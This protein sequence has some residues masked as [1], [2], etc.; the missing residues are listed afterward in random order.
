M[1]KKC[2]VALLLI[3]SGFATT[4]KAGSD[5]EYMKRRFPNRAIYMPYVL[6]TSDTYS[7]GSFFEGYPRRS[8]QTDQNLAWYQARLG[9]TLHLDSLDQLVYGYSAEGLTDAL[10]AKN[11]PAHLRALKSDK[12]LLTYLLIAKEVEALRASKDVWGYEP[13]SE[14]T[15]RRERERLLKTVMSYKQG[16]LLDRYTLLACRLLT[17]Q[18]RYAEVIGLWTER[19]SLFANNVIKEM[20]EGYVARAWHNTGKIKEAKE[21]YQRI[22][23]LES[24]LYIYRIEHKQPVLYQIDQLRIGLQWVTEHP[25]YVRILTRLLNYTEAY[26]LT[27]YK[28][29]QEV[30]KK[31]PNSAFWNYTMAFIYERHK[32]EAPF[33][34][35]EAYAYLKQAQ[36]A[37]K[38]V[39]PQLG[40]EISEDLQKAVTLL[41]FHSGIIYDEA[42]QREVIDWF[43][44]EMLRVL[45]KSKREGFDLYE[46]HRTGLLA[47]LEAEL[48]SCFNTS[49]YGEDHT[50]IR[51]WDNIIQTL[52][53]QNIASNMLTDLYI[54]I[55]GYNKKEWN[56]Y[57]STD[58][59][60]QFFSHT[61]NDE[62][63]A[64]VQAY[65]GN[66][67]GYNDADYLYDA[68]GTKY[69]ASGNYAKAVE[70]LSRVSPRYVEQMNI[71]PF[72]KYDP[73]GKHTRLGHQSVELYKL[74]FAKEM[75]RLKSQMY[76]DRDENTRAEA[77]LRF[78]QGLENAHTTCW[79]LTRYADGMPYTQLPAPGENYDVE[80][81]ALQEAKHLRNTALKLFSDRERQAKAYWAEGFYR[82]VATQFQGTAQAEHARRH[83]DKLK[84]YFSF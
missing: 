14:Q 55:L 53:L 68:L 59:F 37:S 38:Q 70:Y 64:Y 54:D 36:S 44:T 32:D 76:L 33:Y 73:F 6:A 77:M 10:K 21:F 74:N 4:S 2:L 23:D 20:T 63:E 18:D 15:L 8:A 71:R 1:L 31:H 65:V 13:K 11:L 41:S 43:R 3:G 62:A 58:F 7:S 84:H 12:E 61:G 83:C 51:S 72:I 27:I 24:I 19:S 48:S 46:L 78:A 67:E 56:P 66:K 57:Y 50:S 82:T 9:Q 28:L 81:T 69:M 39:S 52:R 49:V 45:H 35:E 26:D 30:L 40:A 79:M 42:R 47:V 60:I 17:A 5:V 34:T 29:G 22:G 25:L 16:S 80:G 75:Q